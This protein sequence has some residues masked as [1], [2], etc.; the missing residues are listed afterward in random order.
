MTAWLLLL[1]DGG[2]S[3]GYDLR[4]ELAASDLQID[5]SVMYRALRRLE[6]EGL[7]ESRWTRSD[8]GP[9]RRLYRLRAKGRR[10][11]DQIAVLI[12]EIRD[13]NDMFVVAHAQALRRRGDAAGGEV[14]APSPPAS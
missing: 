5:P 11:L 14:V 2:A 9:R 12:G 3:Y 8:T 7:V 4:R 13:I 6:R 1:L 10:R